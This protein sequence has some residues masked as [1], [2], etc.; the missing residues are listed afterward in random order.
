MYLAD[1]S[2][3]SQISLGFQCV[4]PQ[5]SIGFSVHPQISIGFQCPP[6][7]FSGDRPHYLLLDAV[8]LCC[9]VVVPAS[10]APTT[11]ARRGPL[12]GLPH[13]REPHPLLAHDRAVG[14]LNY[15]H[16]FLW[17]CFS[18][19]KRCARAHLFQKQIPLTKYV[20]LLR[21]ELHT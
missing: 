18:R 21:S 14:W 20:S 8:C 19:T 15:T 12:R 3:H 4:H 5:I 16:C 1:F 6:T 13:G 17:F 9:V 2:V 10:W 11:R 7:N